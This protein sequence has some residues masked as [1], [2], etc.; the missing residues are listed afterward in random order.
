MRPLL[1]V[2]VLGVTADHA[3]SGSLRVAGTAGC[4][5]EW[6]LGGDVAERISAGIKE[7]FGPLTWKHVGVC[8]PNGPEEKY[9]EIKIQIE[10]GGIG[11]HPRHPLAGGR[12]VYI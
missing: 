8:S 6:E 3:Q 10:I 5:S 12:S 7:F 2:I 11:P 4:L 1:L 9:G